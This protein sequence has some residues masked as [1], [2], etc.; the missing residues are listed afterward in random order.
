MGRPPR[1]QFEGAYYHVFSR[2]NR[3]ER[4][5]RQE[6]DYAVFENVMLEA[7]RW[8]GVQLFDWSQ[9]PN[10]FHFNLQT[11]DGNVA[12]FMQRLLTRYAKY[13]NQTYGLV[14]HVFQGRYGARVVDQETYFKELV[15]YVELNPYRLKHGTLSKLGQWKWASL[16]YLQRAEDQWPEGCQV[17]FRK[18]LERFGK[19]GAVARRNLAIFLAEGLKTGTW[20]DFYHVKDNRFIGDEPFVEKIKRTNDE[21]T[22]SETRCLREGL[23]L[24]DLMG[25]IKIISGLSTMDLAAQDKYLRASRWRQVLTYIARRYYRIPLVQIADKLNRSE[26]TVSLMWARHRGVIEEWPETQ[27]TINALSQKPERFD[28]QMQNAN[29]GT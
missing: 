14:G 5:F 6:K 4:I 28:E 11:P 7:M 18:V 10:H 8:S 26:S 16:R 9:M 19:E 24:E 22:R 15:R 21:P 20:E 17:A 3:R 12:E 23:R 2:G 13:F 27:E 1:L 25:Q 29:T